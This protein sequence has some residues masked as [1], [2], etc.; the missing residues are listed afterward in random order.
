[1]IS[2]SIPKINGDFS[3]IDIGCG[4]GWLVRKLNTFENCLKCTGIDGSES[5]IAKAK[6]IDSDGNYF[7]QKLPDWTPD[8]KVDLVITMEFL[9]YLNNPLKFLSELNKNWLNENGILAIGIDHYFE[10]TSSLSWSDSLGV[11]MTTLSIQEWA[12]GFE[13]AGFSNIEFY[14]YG[15][16]ENWAGTLVI[17][18][19]K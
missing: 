3:A 13:D 19:Q 2:K 11:S 18:G 17:V 10:N 14:Q 15:A 7:C 16:K 9:Y 6:K 1:M 12:K 8:E 4:N 5:M